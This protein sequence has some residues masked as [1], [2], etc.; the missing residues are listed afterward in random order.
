MLQSAPLSSLVTFTRASAALDFDQS[1]TLVSAPV[2][3][4]RRGWDPISRAALGWLVEA[5]AVQLL[6]NS[7][8]GINS[9]AGNNTM[10]ISTD[11]APPFP[12]ATVRKHTRV[13]ASGGDDNTGIASILQ[14]NLA[15]STQYAASV[16]VW[17]PSGVT[18]T[19]ANLAIESGGFGTNTR[20]VPL[21]L[22]KRDQWQRVVTLAS[23]PATL[24]G[25]TAMVLRTGS[26]DGGFLYTACPQFEVGYGAT[27]YVHTTGSTASRAADVASVS[28]AAFAAA[29]RMASRT[30]LLLRSESIGTSPW[31][32]TST[33][34]QN[35]ADLVAPDGAS[36]ATKAT[37]AGA[38]SVGQGVQSVAGP[39]TGSIWLRTAS[40]TVACGLVLYRNS[41]NTV[42]GNITVTATTTWTRFQ[43][44]AQFLDTSA[45]NLQVNMPAGSTVYLWGGQIEVAPVPVLANLIPYPEDFGSWASNGAPNDSTVVRDAGLAPDLTATADKIIPSTGTGSKGLYSGFAGAVSTTYTGSVHLKAAGY[46]YAYVQFVNT[47]FG[48]NAK[49]AIVDLQTGT[50]TQQDA[51]S[52]ATLTDAGNGWWR[53][54]ISATSLGTSGNFI[55]FVGV[56]GNTNSANTITGW[57]GN[58]TDGV[59]AWGAE[60]EAGAAA[61]AYPPASQLVGSYIPTVAA[62][63]SKTGAAE[64][65]VVL[66]CVVSALPVSPANAWIAQVDDG[67]PDNRFYLFLGGGSAVPLVRHKAGRNSFAPTDIYSGVVA[68]GTVFRIGIRWGGAGMA[69]NTFALCFNGA[70]PSIAAAPVPAGLNNLSLGHAFGAGQLNGRIRGVWT[71]ARAPSDSRMRAACTL[72]ADVDAALVA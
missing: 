18:L 17:V 28:G 22:T 25:N 43:V 9:A 49:Q 51:G 70:A 35:T 19:G 27:G 11:V 66:E 41:P 14:A 29:F 72:G 6:A 38:H 1:G 48:A 56:N 3:T 44:S 62:Q 58:G 21:D 46:R 50:I 52:N 40:G 68:A 64:G 54:A 5:S 36:T 47:A 10:V 15:P 55:F 8:A 60:V 63:A 61:T 2:D 31:F 4:L 39:H 45:H 13:V 42:V 26:A 33:L 69:A 24:T 30:N 12:G 59:L 23:S 32:T 53:L 57:A 16:F 7:A 34:T 20:P 71:S 65:F 67:S 37:A